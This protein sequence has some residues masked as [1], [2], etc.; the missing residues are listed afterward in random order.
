[1]ATGDSQQSQA[2]N[3]RVGRSTAC[4]VIR[5]TCTGIWIALN[6]IYLKSPNTANEWEQIANGMEESWN[7]PNCIGA[8]DGKHIAIECP[9]NSGSS[10]FNYKKFHSLVLMA[11]CDA[12]YC[13]T[14]VDIG[15][16]GRD[17]DANIFNNS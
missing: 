9:A 10:Y 3:F 17:N 2:F 4:N 6:E 11:M 13:F 1:M 12:Q 14:L 7:F 5:E 8:L 16:Y 15:H